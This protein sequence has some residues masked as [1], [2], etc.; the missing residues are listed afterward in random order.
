VDERRVAVLRDVRE[1]LSDRCVQR[2]V[3]RRCGCGGRRCCCGGRRGGCGCGLLL[4]LLLLLLCRQRCMQRSRLDRS[5]VLL[6]RCLRLRELVLLRLPCQLH[7]RHRV[8]LR[9]V[10]RLL[11]LRGVQRRQLPLRR[12]LLMRRQLLMRRLLLQRRLLLRRVL[13]HRGV[14]LRGALLGI[15]LRGGGSGL[16]RLLPRRVLLRRGVLLRGALLGILL[17]GGGRG[18]L[19]LLLLLDLRLLLRRLLVPR[20]LSLLRARVPRQYV[21]CHWQWGGRR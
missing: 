3:L 18:L 17:R 11:L 1:E 6:R 21:A 12:L 14:L 5:R 15:L 13:L 16:L 7:A 19:R 9:S 10:Q 20:H 2:R 4:V 8:L